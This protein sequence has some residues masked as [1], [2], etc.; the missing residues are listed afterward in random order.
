MKNFYMREI[1]WYASQVEWQK[2]HLK[3]LKKFEKNYPNSTTEE[4]IRIATSSLNH[5]RY[6]LKKY[7]KLVK[8][9]V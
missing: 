8:E 4:T 2:N 7:T 1:E 5:L 9:M 6:M 3:A